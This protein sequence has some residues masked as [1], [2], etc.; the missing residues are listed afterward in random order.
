MYETYDGIN[1]VL[2]KYDLVTDSTS[3]LTRFKD[4]SKP[5]GMKN[6]ISNFKAEI[7]HG[8]SVKLT[9]T[10]YTEGK[11]FY[12]VY[13][14]D[15][16]EAVKLD[17]V[18]S[19]PTGE[20]TQEQV[21][22]EKIFYTDGYAHIKDLKMGVEN[23]FKV[24]IMEND[25]PVASSQL[26]RL[27]IPEV[28]AI[29]TVTAD[30]EN[31]YLVKLSAWKPET[32]DE[33]EN[34][35]F[36]WIIDNQEIDAGISE[37][38]Y[39]EF[40]TSGMKSISLK[41]HNKA[42]TEM[43]I[44]DPVHFNV[45][46]D[47]VPVI[48]YVLAE[49]GSSIELSA[50]NS[51][52]NKIDF[53]NSV[54]NIS[55]AGGMPMAPFTGSRR[56][57]SLDNYKNK[58]SINL[59][60]KRLPV[61][62]QGA[63]DSIEVNK[64]IDLDY[65]EV[66]PIITYTEDEE[67]KNLFTFH[68]SE[69]IGNIDWLNAQWKIMKD[70]H[71]IHQERSVSSMAYHFG[72]SS[73]NELY[74]VY[75]SVPRRNDGMTMTVSQVINTNAVELVPVIDYEVLTLEEN[76][77]VTGAKV[78]FNAM[79]SKGSNIDFAQA[80][81]NVPVAGQYGEQ[82]TQ[83]GPTAIF[84]L[85]G[86]TDKPTI[87]VNLT[88]SRRGISA[89]VT[90]TET[91]NIT[92]DKI[93]EP[94]LIVN[95]TMKEGTTGQI[96][97]LDVLS[98]KGT[99]INWSET[100][101]VL[102][103]GYPQTGPVARY[104]IPNTGEKTI[105][106][107]VATL[108]LFTGQTITKHGQY[109]V[110]KTGIEPF[111]EYKEIADKTY[112]LSVSNTEGVNIDWQ[113]TIWSIYDGNSEVVRL[114]GANVMHSFKPKEEAM[115]YPVIVEMYLKNSSVP[116]YAYESIDIEGDIMTP[117]IS[118]DYATDR[119]DKNVVLFSAQKST[120]SN[121]L[122]SQTKWTFGDSSEAQYGATAVHKYPLDKTDRDYKVSMT[123]TRR[124]RDGTE[125]VKTT[126]KTINIENDVITPKL[127][128]NYDKETGMLILSASESEGRGLMLDRSMWIFEGEGDTYSITEGISKNK[129]IS[130]SSS[131]NKS[132]TI[133]GHANVGYSVSAA[134]APG[135]E[136]S[137]STGI[138]FGASNTEGDSNS[139][140]ESIS[141]SISNSGTYS[142]SNSHTGAVVR[143]YIDPTSIEKG[144]DHLTTVTLF[145][146]RIGPDGS[147]TGESTMFNISLNKASESEGVLYE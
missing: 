75:L 47:I 25:E 127:R 58:L 90:I 39:Y 143:R 77:V 140:G 124:F 73:K 123:L 80:R 16:E 60:L 41:V 119:E 91:I 98:S 126:T 36:K 35:Y 21:T 125:E 109:I 110:D 95:K 61:N 79:N 117:V 128:A 138:Q 13:Y 102:D 66:K 57:I 104:E 45:K 30:E 29:P 101:W 68:G 31:P 50:A 55:G 6:T 115:G 32:L 62:N 106:N 38:Y 96:I 59:V 108:K 22:V 133:S 42:N 120:G 118:W 17:P 82:P 139:T 130:T 116:F 2:N 69:S 56:I 67:V 113:R 142:S 20:I 8:N 48:E 88:L 4:A 84:N 103:N 141:D 78:L 23:T 24:V 63:T 10:P 65:K 52:G 74:T 100:S 132:L 111:I 107:W 51:L 49:D 76:G 131:T 28:V 43:E 85:I 14:N 5:A 97:V 9:W 135:A 105:I 144:K 27:Y 7:V 3:E 114:Q 83:I 89:P 122:W 145:I 33:G 121:I 44:S 71:I 112:S 19:E 11:T 99:N 94:E 46:S 26:L 1:A 37:H 92:S 70:G 129:S 54:W 87:D 34:W 86:A 15:Y 40:S 146:Y 93:V 53:A 137:F 134:I 12:Y 81:W 147:L 136:V 72:E 18:T 64:F